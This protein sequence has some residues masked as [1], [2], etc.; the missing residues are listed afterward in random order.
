MNKFQNKYRIPS[1]RLQT[2]DY[3]AAAY[4]FV[5]I[6]TANR[7][8]FF[9]QIVNGEMQLSPIGEIVASE[10]E[11]SIEIR[12]DMNL[13][14]DAY[15]VMPD[16]FHAIIGIGENEYNSQS[17][18]S[19]N[20]FG[21][22]SHNLASIIRGFKSAVT[23]NARKIHADFGWQSRF[24]DRIIRDDAAHE[25]IRNYIINNPKKWDDDTFRGK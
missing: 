7:E 9:G 22:Q 24:H 1:A 2:W 3:G 15:V 13:Q 11:K 14:L 4:Y 23:I 10:W 21:P 19:P 5:T 25:N 6:C 18:P 20:Q 16:H 8:H 17:V 12:P